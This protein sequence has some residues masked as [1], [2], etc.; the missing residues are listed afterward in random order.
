MVL[1]LLSSIGYD[2][3]FDEIL[4][5]VVQEIRLDIWELDDANLEKLAN[6]VLSKSIKVNMIDL[7]TFNCCLAFFKS[8]VG[9]K[10][11]TSGCKRLLLA[12]P[13]DGLDTEIDVN[14]LL[15]LLK[16][17]T[18]LKLGIRQLQRLFD[19]D[20]SLQSSRLECLSV[21]VEGT[22]SVEFLNSVQQDIQ[23]WLLSEN[24]PGKKLI[25]E[26]CIGFPVEFDQALKYN[27]YE[28]VYDYD[29]PSEEM[30]LEYVEKLGAFLNKNRDLNIEI[31]IQACLGVSFPSLAKL[32]LSSLSANN[33]CFPTSVS[34][35]QL[36]DPE[37]NSEELPHVFN[38][39]TQVPH[40]R[41]F[42]I[43]LSPMSIEPETTP[44]IIFSSSS[45]IELNLE[46]VMCTPERGISF[47]TLNSLEYLDLY[48]CYMSADFL[49]H[50]PD[51]LKS[52]SLYKVV[53][54]S[55][56]DGVRFPVGLKKLEYLGDFHQCT[57]PLISNFGDLTKLDYVAA[58]VSSSGEPETTS[59]EGE[60]TELPIQSFITNLPTQVKSLVL[61][62]ECFPKRSSEGIM[63]CRTVELLHSLSMLQDLDFRCDYF[64]ISK[65]LF[66]LLKVFGN[67]T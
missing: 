19:L 11:L 33:C 64:L 45:I 49:S 67:I 63:I 37:Y 28:G 26:P 48:K 6:F 55:S 39:L 46:F 24:I 27:H 29:E 60:Q 57:L 17:V 47:E 14:D 54:Q 35:N 30:V 18:F 42:E 22:L 7:R 43:A 1:Q 23:K 53:L 44:N 38:W 66:N 8:P 4:S 2:S 41:K 10:F 50:L 20:F 58:K 12:V 3:K 56:S 32:L 34:L 36:S 15:P 13:E 62:T 21:D 25:L 51:S 65:A 40:L 52:L 31:D 61:H 59:F 5:L 9:K 16:D